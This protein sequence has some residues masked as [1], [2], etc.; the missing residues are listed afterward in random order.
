MAFESIRARW[1]EWD[2]RAEACTGWA[3]EVTVLARAAD[4]LG[5]T[6]R[7][8]ANFQVPRS[9]SV[10]RARE[11]AVRAWARRE[12]AGLLELAADAAEAA[13]GGGGA[14]RDS[15]GAATVETVSA[16]WL[17]RSPLAERARW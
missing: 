1:N 3:S 9:P 4:V 10:R 12:R 14:R 5:R 11:E 13:M 16:G 17:L 2:E 8:G 6:S 15:L 7:R